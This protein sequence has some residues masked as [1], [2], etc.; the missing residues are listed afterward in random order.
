[1]VLIAIVYSDKNGG[2]W[3]PVSEIMTIETPHVRTVTSRVK[4]QNV[5]CVYSVIDD[6]FKKN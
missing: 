5:L 3:M 1:M 6:I 2:E 4:W